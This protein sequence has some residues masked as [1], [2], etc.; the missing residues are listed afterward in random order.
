MINPLKIFVFFQLF[1]VNEK[2]SNVER[3]AKETAE[4]CAEISDK[5]KTSKRC[6]QIDQL[7]ESNTQLKDVIF[8]DPTWNRWHD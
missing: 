8:Y 4:K 2:M 3:F 6:K 7:K 5:R 1:E